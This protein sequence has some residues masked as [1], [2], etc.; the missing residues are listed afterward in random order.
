[1]NYY[2]YL[3]EQQVGPYTEE[4]IRALVAT[5]TAAQTDLCWHEGITDW[6]LLNSVLSFQQPPSPVVPPASPTPETKKCPFCAEQISVE[7][8][9]CKHCGETVDVALRAAEEAKRTSTTQPSQSP[10][11]LAVTSAHEEEIWSGSPSQLLNIKLYLIWGLLLIGVVIAGLI[12]PQSF[13]LFVVLI[14]IALIQ[15]IFAYLKIKKTR[16]L[17][18]NQRVKITTGIFSQDIQEV[19]LFR[20]KDTAAHQPFFMRL[21]KLG[22][23][24]LV[25]GDSKNPDIVLVAIPN[26]RETRERIRQEVLILRQ[27]LGVREIGVM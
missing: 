20:V 22:L 10:A 19:E 3:N 7:A 2:L 15:C 6:Q 21:F 17:I 4:Q 12:Q 23:I 5:G 14:P 25:S 26:P 1:M 18:T 9:K 24:E 13:L 16:Y 11:G 8:K 27:K